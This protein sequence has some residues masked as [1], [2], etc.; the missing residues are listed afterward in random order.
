MQYGRQPACSI[1]SLS[2]YI[3]LAECGQIRA[4]KSHCAPGGAPLALTVT[5]PKSRH[6][7]LLTLLGAFFLA[8]KHPQ[9]RL[10]TIPAQ[11]SRGFPNFQ[12]RRRPVRQFRAPAIPFR[13]ATHGRSATSAS[14]FHNIILSCRAN[15]IEPAAATKVSTDL[16]AKLT[17]LRIYGKLIVYAAW[18]LRGS[19][20]TRRI[21]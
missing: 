4:S 16:V 14:R 21:F 9:L 2:N 11:T 10:Q 7:D 12:N 18:F 5:N 3:P 1:I 17:R 20:V 8:M 13:L 19:S 6:S 15:F